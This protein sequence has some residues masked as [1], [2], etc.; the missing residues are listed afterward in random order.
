LLSRPYAISKTNQEF[1]LTE[2]KSSSYRRVKLLFLFPL[3]QGGGFTL[4]SGRLRPVWGSHGHPLQAR[5]FPDRSVNTVLTR[6]T[7]QSPVTTNSAA[8]ETPPRSPVTTRT[9]TS[10]GCH[11]SPPKLPPAKGVIRHRQ[12]CHWLRVLLLVT[13]KIVSSFRVLLLAIIKVAVGLGTII[14]YHGNFGCCFLTVGV[15]L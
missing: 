6:P 10:K 7:R 3:A 15:V 5:T 8:A 13:A 12:N 1:P 11:L 2:R 9:A 4:R 14:C